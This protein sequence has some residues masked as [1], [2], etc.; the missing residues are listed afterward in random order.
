M[1]EQP[2]VIFEFEVPR[3]TVRSTISYFREH[4]YCDIRLWI[5][6]SPGE[7]LV[8][9]KKGIRLPAQYVDDLEEAVAA[10]AAAVRRGGRA[11]A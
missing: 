1:A 2:E 11:A 9:T 6:R 8:P 7:D 3:G 5:E 4:P 10:L